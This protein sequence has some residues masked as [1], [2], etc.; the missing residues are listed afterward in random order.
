MR[1]T[2]FLASAFLLG[3]GGLAMAQSPADTSLTPT[4]MSQNWS[5]VDREWFYGFSQG[6][7][8]IPYDWYLALEQKDS[9]TLFRADGLARFGYLPRPFTPRNPDALPVGFTADTDNRG[10]WFGMNCAACHV[11]RVSYQGHIY[12]VD[13]APG[14]G[15]LGALISAIA[16]SLDAT[17]ADPAKF[18]RFYNRIHAHNPA[19]SQAALRTQL[20]QG[21]SAFR[22]FVT[23]STPADAWGPGRTDAFGMIFN[24]VTAIDLNNDRNSQI[25]N[26]PVSLPF[27]W[28]TSRQDKVQWNGMVDNVSWYARLGRNVGQVLGVFGQVPGLR[29]APSYASMKLRNSVHTGALL[30]L[31]MRI[32]DLTSP[33]WVGPPVSSSD[34]V[35][36]HGKEVFQHT[37]AACHIDASSTEASRDSASRWPCPSWTD[38]PKV[39]DDLLPVCLTPM[40]KLGT[41]SLMNDNVVRYR[42]ETGVLD[43]YRPLPSFTA[44]GESE[45]RGDILS[46]VVIGAIL[47]PAPIPASSPVPQPPQPDEDLLGTITI[48]TR[49]L[50][51]TAGGSMPA[52]YIPTAAELSKMVY[53]GGPLNGIWATAP[54]LHNGSVPTL[55]DLLKPAAERPKTFW[56]GNRELDADNVGFVSSSGRFLFDTAKAGNSNAG[57]EY[58]AR[59]PEADKAALIQYMKTL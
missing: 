42:A 52:T 3:A 26:A 47:N 23:Q 7:Q 21:A 4:P 25:P 36:L 27:L 43:G 18:Q 56:V 11:N 45:L 41:D 17:L 48:K 44:L 35:T 54:Y 16:D 15:D 50:L 32:K 1:N 28:T 12:Q 58:G 30:L 49:L 39:S 6:S 34:P 53:K 13:G 57:H 10:L 2:V 29:D 14:L 51:A 19:L 37:C 55:A 22:K 5:S 31:D 24:R 59:L 33:G 40:T 20:E 38:T 46:P 8:I 9:S